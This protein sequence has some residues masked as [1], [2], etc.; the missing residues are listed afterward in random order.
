MPVTLF[1]VRTVVVE[2][3]LYTTCR[4]A[5]SGTN[6]GDKLLSTLAQEGA[7]SGRGE[8]RNN[9][10][11]PPSYPDQLVDIG[12]PTPFADDLES[13]RTPSSTDSSSTKSVEQGG[14]G[15]V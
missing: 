12:R 3:R 4:A 14:R 7:L 8:T 13:N 10:A 1:E 5:R 15:R 2:Y 9:L 6:P 11:R